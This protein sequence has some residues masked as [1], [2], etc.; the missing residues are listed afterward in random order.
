MIGNIV[1]ALSF[2]IALIGM[3]RFKKMTVPFKLLAIWLVIDFLLDASNQYFIDTYK[4][5]ARLSHVLCILEYIFYAVIYYHLFRSNYIKKFILV[6]IALFIA[7]FIINALFLQPF[8][9]V[10]PTNVIMSAEILYVLFAILLFK[11]MLQYPLQMNIMKQSV[12]WFN[13]SILFF[14][15]T[16]FLNLGLM[17]YYGKYHSDTITLILYFWYSI[18]IIFSILLGIALLNDKK[19]SIETN[20]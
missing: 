2:I 9:R 6:T 7:F 8:T 3:V 18:D 17:N 1:L 10:F 12:F 13:T 20:G 5:N 19:E 11:Q 14:S 15:T 16:M 4:N